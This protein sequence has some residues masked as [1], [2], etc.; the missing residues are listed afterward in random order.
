V[1]RGCR[2]PHQGSS[3][4]ARITDDGVFRV[5]EGARRRI[6]ANETLGMQ[7]GARR[8]DFGQTRRWAE[9]KQRA[10]GASDPEQRIADQDVDQVT[11]EVLYH[12]RPL[13][14]AHDDELRLHS[15][16]GYNRWLA[17][18]CSYAPDRLVGVAAI[19]TDAPEVALA[20]IHAAV[21]LGFRT[22]Y[23]ALFPPS[24]SYAQPAWDPVWAELADLGRPVGMHIGDLRNEERRYDDPGIFM[25]QN[26]TARLLMA[27]ALGELIFGG[28]LQRHPRLTVGSVEAQVGWLSFAIAHMDQVWDKHRHWSHSTLDEPPSSYFQRQVFATFTHDPVGM[29][30]LR[31][32]GVDRVMWSS[33]YPHAETSWPNSRA[34][35][36]HAL[37]GYDDDERDKV[38]WKN[39]ADLYG[40]PVDATPSEIGEGRATATSAPAPTRG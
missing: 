32:I 6:L 29:R 3:I 24:G 19:P 12:G 35:A 10:S 22:V 40:I 36:E 39:A 5:F 13:V 1:V 11:A 8:A 16:R 15:F 4:F 20:E 21:R 2:V 7:A 30:E 18:F 26:L 23:V 14:D 27:E 17:D 28:V 33:D 37:E 31:H 34:T 38:L 25:T 9:E